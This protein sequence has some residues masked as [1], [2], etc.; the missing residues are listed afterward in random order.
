MLTWAC[1]AQVLKAWEALMAAALAALPPERQPAGQG[2][3]EGL[4]RRRLAGS[5]ASTRRRAEN[6]RIFADGEQNWVMM[7]VRT[8][9]KAICDV[10]VTN[11]CRPG[12]HARQ[13]PATMPRLPTADLD[14]SAK[15]GKA[16]LAKPCRSAILGY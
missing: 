7:Q 6:K 1:L 15:Q 5:E 8:F 12:V 11:I 14:P 3:L 2:A 9:L 10:T 4:V 16:W 13:V